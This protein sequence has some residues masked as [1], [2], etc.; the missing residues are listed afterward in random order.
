MYSPRHRQPVD[1]LKSSRCILCRFLETRDIFIECWW[2]DRSYHAEPPLCCAIRG[3]LSYT[4]RSLGL[5]GVFELCSLRWFTQI[6]FSYY[7]LPN[8]QNLEV[9]GVCRLLNYASTI[10]FRSYNS[11]IPSSELLKHFEVIRRHTGLLPIHNTCYELGVSES[12]SQ[13]LCNNDMHVKSHR[14]THMKSYVVSRIVWFP[15]IN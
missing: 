15:L 8:G 10:K 9:S 4:M 13:K 11:P 12:E 2:L 7:K 5:W 6:Y 14:M 1:T 3:F